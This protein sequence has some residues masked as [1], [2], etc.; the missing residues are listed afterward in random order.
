MLKVIAELSDL[1][2]RIGADDAVNLDGGGS[3]T[4]VTRGPG[5]TVPTVRN[6]PSGVAERPVANAIGVFSGR[7]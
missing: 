6:H 5:E 3:T 1:M 4:L 2:G 7:P